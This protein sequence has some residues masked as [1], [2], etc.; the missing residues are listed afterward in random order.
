MKTIGVV[1]IAGLFILSAFGAAALQSDV[2]TQKEFN[3][4]TRAFTHTV[5]AEDGTATWCG[6]C[7]YA[8]EAL[9]KI[10][11]SGDYP[12]YY[13]CLV[14][15][16]NT[17]AAWRVR[18]QYNIYGFPTVWFDG[19]Y[20]VAVGGG[21][22]NE[23]QYRNYINNYCGPR[24]VSDIDVALNVTWL[25]NAAMDISASVKNNEAGDY[26]GFL[27][28][29]VTEVESSMGWHDT[30]G[31]PYTFPF[32]Q[33]AYNGSIT[34][35]GGDTWTST[36]S[37]DGHNFN[38]GH[39][40]NYGSIQYGNIM[41]IAVVYNNLWHQGYSNPPSGYPFDAYYVDDCTGFWIGDNTPPNVPSNPSP[42][43]G[44]VSIDLNKD[45]SWVGGDP[46]P[47]HDTVTYDV[48]FG[49]TNPP[50]L[51]ASNQSK[52]TYDPG[53][54]TYET[55]YYWQ[56][57]A[58]DNHGASTQGPVWHFTTLNRPNTPPSAPTIQGP[59]EGK[60]KTLYTYTLTATDSESDP[61]Y[62]LVDWG[63]NTT[64]TWDGPHDSG[65]PITLSHTWSLKGTFNVRAK[66]KDNHD[67]ESAWGTLTVTIPTSFDYHHHFIFMELIEK[68]LARFPIFER[69]FLH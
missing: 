45:L 5:F 14:D 27:R 40:H 52:T 31:H 30:T 68:I 10:Y 58:T 13:V 2:T 41:I 39:G 9:D 11:M 55:M 37:W 29:Y 50:P 26:G 44:A 20:K 28:I 63:D 32:L 38:D 67:A 65:Q 56:I 21:T 42:A 4:G 43:N 69:L 51:V 61:V 24:A 54:M 60:P 3:Q 18:T 8:R 6:Y 53:T 12:F 7:H 35:P 25:G 36:I 16:M 57:V 47:S 19:G 64:T 62:Y 34:I 15:D 46:D 1:C 17:A 22:G 49:T 23:A 66:A 59:G 48:Y 33:Y